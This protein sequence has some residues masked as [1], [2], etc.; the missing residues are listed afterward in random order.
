MPRLETVAQNSSTV[1]LS[2][3]NYYY[4][5][6]TTSST[7]TYNLPV[8]TC[9]GMRFIFTRN[10][11]DG[12]STLIIQSASALQ[13]NSNG[14]LVSSISVSP[15]SN[16]ILISSSSIWYAMEYNNISNISNN[17]LA[18]ATFVSNNGNPYR[19]V[20]GTNTIIGYLYFP[21]T[22][23]TSITSMLLV[24]SF[25]GLVPSTI[26]VVDKITAGI[27]IND[28][29]ISATSGIVTLIL[30]GSQIDNSVISPNPTVLTISFTISSGA[31]N[32]YSLAFF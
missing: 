3:Q 2:I 6:P 18:S 26:R 7:F 4:S 15:L 24:I 11:N 20:S 30:T 28:E 31:F 14:T 29:P 1:D 10:D 12:T 21:G 5:A 22:L 17:A 8:I 9:D 19:G 27:I 25:N 32:L 13:I 23:I 16:L